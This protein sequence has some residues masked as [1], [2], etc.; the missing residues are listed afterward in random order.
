MPVQPLPTPKEGLYV[1]GGSGNLVILKN[2]P[3][4]NATKLF[5][6]WVLSKEGQEVYSKAL[7]QATR[8]LDVDTKWLQEMGVSA[9]KDKLTLEQYH[10]LENQSEEKLKRSREPA[11]ALARK[12]LGQ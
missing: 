10:R 7:G 11:A 6:N 9:A 5:V 4:P 3:H 8:R 2:A 12:L 1:S